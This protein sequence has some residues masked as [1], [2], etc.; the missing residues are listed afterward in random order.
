MIYATVGQTQAHVPDAR[1]LIRSSI[2]AT[3]QLKHWM[4]SAAVHL[5]DFGPY[6]YHRDFDLTY[7]LQLKGSVYR[8]L[9]RPKPNERVSR[10]GFTASFRTLDENSDY[11]ELYD[12]DN[13]PY[14]LEIG[15]HLQVGL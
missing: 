12:G 14:Q 5:S 8:M 4:A 10:W 13:S 11:F 6:D 7:P 9:K 15:T 3:A 2:E 1:L